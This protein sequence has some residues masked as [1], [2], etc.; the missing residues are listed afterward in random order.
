V[1][2]GDLVVT[3]EAYE[4]G[5]ETADDLLTRALGDRLDLRV[6]VGELPYGLAVSGVEVSADG[7]TVVA[8]AGR[9]VLGRS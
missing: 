2:G 8:A 5:N 7:V 1:D 3:A 6:P 4:V 9:T